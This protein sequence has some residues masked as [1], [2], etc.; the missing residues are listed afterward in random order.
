MKQFYTLFACLFII[1]TMYAQPGSLDKSFGQN[2]KTLSPFPFSCNAL[3]MQADGKIL[4]GGGG[5]TIKNGDTLR[6]L[7]T[8]YNA[9]G[10]IDIGFGDSGRAVMGTNL[11]ILYSPEIAA[12]AVQSDGKIVGAGKIATL[13][14]QTDILVA[15]FN[16]DGSIDKGFG[17]EGTIRVDLGLA[18]ITTGIALQDDGK[19]L[20]S[21][22]KANYTGSFVSTFTLRFL[23][24]GNV[25][26][27][28]GDKGKVLTTGFGLFAQVHGIGIYQ[29]KIM[30]GITEYISQVPHP[31]QSYVVLK[32]LQNGQIDSSYGIN[33]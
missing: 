3:V 9:D 16:N 26:N 23:P 17:D 1:A 6:D 18:E 13:P 15:R 10:S 21:G 30:I 12:L 24:D 7:I 32:Y 22:M 31:I 8:R 29:D 25:D 20:V 5:G 14:Q 27:S 11:G 19:I 4:A 2:G 28:F 33:G